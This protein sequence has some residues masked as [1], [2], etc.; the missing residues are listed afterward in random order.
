MIKWIVL[1]LTP[2]LW[3]EY[4]GSYQSAAWNGGG[5]AVSQGLA[6]MSGNPAGLSLFS[7]PALETGVH[8]LDDFTSTYTLGGLPVGNRSSFALG[9]NGFEVPDFY[10]KDFK[11]ALAL[12]PFEQMAFGILAIGQHADNELNMDFHVGLKF[13]WRPWVSWGLDVRNLVENRE[14]SIYEL[15]TQRTFGTGFWYLPFYSVLHDRFGIY[16]DWQNNKINP[17][18]GSLQSGLELKLGPRKNL[19]M[20][21]S[22]EIQ[23]NVN[24]D[25]SL[26]GGVKIQE[27]FFDHLVGFS[28]AAN[29][30]YSSN[31]NKN[32]NHHIAVYL[33]ID[34][35][36]D[37]V[38]PEVSLSLDRALLELNNPDAPQVIH[39]YLK[40]EDDRNKIYSW[41]LVISSV[42]EKWKATEVVKSFNG[43]G[44]PPKVIQWG[45]KTTARQKLNSGFYSFRLLVYD[46]EKNL[47]A[48]KWQMFEIR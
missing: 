25:Y 18:D 35:F 36:R 13:T 5:R 47:S 12:K 45:G 21:A 33:R 22:A 14:S 24:K 26:S 23:N 31:L 10:R 6:A 30:L 40:A 7:S 37:I 32:M 38:P 48:S 17:R 16:L 11:A 20:H 39:F 46:Q 3:A 8:I 29:Q 9:I 1:T 2:I 4:F 42:D 28:Y 44:L 19:Q 43:K 41:H 34:P 15:N 27:K